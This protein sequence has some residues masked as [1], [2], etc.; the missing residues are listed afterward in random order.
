MP[1]LGVPHNRRR[2]TIQPVAPT[3]PMA[4]PEAL[5]LAGSPGTIAG[6]L[7]SHLDVIQRLARAAAR[8]AG[9]PLSATDDFLSD[10]YLKLVA[11]DYAVLRSYQGRSRLTTFLMTV[12]QRVAYDFRNARWGRWRPSAEAERLGPSALRLEEL[13]Y[14]EGLTFDEACGYLCSASDAPTRER[15]YEVL[16]RLPPRPRP[17]RAA[18]AKHLDLVVDGQTPESRAAES[19]AAVQGERLQIALKRVCDRLTPQEAL[20]LRLRFQDELSLAV[21]ARLLNIDEKRVYRQFD[22]ILLEVRRAL[23]A[24]GFTAEAALGVVHGLDLKGL[25][26]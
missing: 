3:A 17:D 15:L 1:Y 25:L 10:V 8:R 2:S 6:W 20:A 19:E 24:E 4:V 13:I 11:D 26:P 5:P 14:R 9:L 22:H 23:E 21:I 16:L 18:E 12:F 7:E